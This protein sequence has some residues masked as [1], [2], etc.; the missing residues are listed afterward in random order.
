MT[1]DAAL[2]LALFAIIA[3]C[4]IGQW[5]TARRSELRVFEE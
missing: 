2:L 4:L 3:V 5:A 1:N